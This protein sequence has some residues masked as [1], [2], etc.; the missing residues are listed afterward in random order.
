MRASKQQ[1]SNDESMSGPLTPY[2]LKRRITWAALIKCVYE[3]DPLKCPNCCAEMKIVGFIER[4]ET[5]LIRMVLSAAGLWKE[6]VP[7]A[8]PTVPVAVTVHEEPVVDYE[9]FDKTCV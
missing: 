9:F 7:R 8:P 1:V 2:Q 3:V 4:E 6:P 5:V